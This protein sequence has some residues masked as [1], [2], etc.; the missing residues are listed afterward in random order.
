[1]ILGISIINLL[2]GDC[3]SIMVGLHLKNH[4]LA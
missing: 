3:I 4:D 2:K 1:M